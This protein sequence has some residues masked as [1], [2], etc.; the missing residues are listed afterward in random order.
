MNVFLNPVNVQEPISEIINKLDE[1]FADM[2]AIPTYIISKYAKKYVDV[3]LTG[4]SADELF[5]GYSKYLENYYNELYKK[6]PLFLRKNIVERLVYLAPNDYS[7]VRKMRKVMENVNKDPFSRRKELMCL[8]FTEADL[9]VLLNGLAD[10]EFSSFIRGYYDKYENLV[11]EL[12][13]VLYTD[14]KV[15]LEGDILFKV[16]KMTSLSFLEARMPF[17]SKDVMEIAARIPS[18]YKMSGSKQKIILKEAF[19]DIIPVKNQNLS[20]K[21]FGIPLGKWF[22]GLLKEELL[23]LLNREYLVAQ[24]L[25]NYEF[26]NCLL[27]EHFTGKK[28]RASELWILYVFQHW[29]R[30]FFD[31]C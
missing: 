1:P 25:F 4:D 27:D 21:G 18:Q 6:I 22:R 2:S 23:G 7:L 11:D 16:K 15:V 3:V 12:V 31:I 14:F 13:Q 17:L 8:G 19:K 5:A 26:I 9:K 28:D 10:G 30:R 29:Y 20:K 24:G